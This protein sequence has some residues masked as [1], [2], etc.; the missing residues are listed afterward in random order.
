ME[1]SGYK[2]CVF[3]SFSQTYDFYRLV[4]KLTDMG[5]AASGLTGTG[6]VEIKILDINDNMPT[7]EKSEVMNMAFTCS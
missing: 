1:V 2:S 6:T 5:G 3:T 4:I 7:L